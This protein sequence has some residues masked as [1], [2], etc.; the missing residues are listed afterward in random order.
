MPR[1]A[2]LV[3]NNTYYHILTRGNNRQQLF[4]EEKDFNYFLKLI[5]DSKS[6][7]EFDLYHYC[8]MSNHIHL[9]LKIIKA[10]DLAKLL[11]SLKLSYSFYFRKKY[12]N[13][14]YIFQG[15]YKSLL[16]ENDAYLFDC[17]R[18]IERNPLRAKIVER[19]EDYRYT[20]YKFYALGEGNPILTE[21]I[22]YAQL[23][24]SA[25]ERQASYRDYVSKP[26]PY[27]ELID[28]EFILR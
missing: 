18:Y 3:I 8:L 9:L 1:S 15:R 20:S 12:S 11:K 28:R 4:K 25:Q 17:G 23:G 19:L 13:S 16:I 21:N 2:R 10:S 22:L 7:F 6:E 27:E 24:N 5:S 26:R 14:G